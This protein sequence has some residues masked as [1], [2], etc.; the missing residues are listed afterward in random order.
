TP[1][2]AD[3]A[4]DAVLRQARAWSVD[5]GA[6]AY[7]PTVCYFPA[8]A[9]AGATVR[10]LAGDAWWLP[11]MSGGEPLFLGET[12]RGYHILGSFSNLVPSIADA[13]VVWSTQGK[14]KTTFVIPINTPIELYDIRGQPL[15]QKVKGTKFTLDLDETPVVVKGVRPGMVFP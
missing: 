10:L 4:V 14:Q 13:T 12:V 15:K 2:G 9:S 7:R 8:M 1:A 5:P 11:S 6:A 3:G